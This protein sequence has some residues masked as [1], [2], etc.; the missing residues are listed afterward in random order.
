LKDNLSITLA[1]LFIVRLYIYIY[2]NPNSE[3]YKQVNSAASH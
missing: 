1:I 2:F 3:Q